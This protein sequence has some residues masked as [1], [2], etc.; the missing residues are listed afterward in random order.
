MKLG[1][2]LLAHG[3]IRPDALNLGIEVDPQSNVVDATGNPDRSLY[4]V[5]PMTRGSY[6]EIV[7][8]PDIRRQC[9]DLARRLANAGWVAEGL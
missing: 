8:V 6:W 5:G 3:R 9:A 7:A 1:E 4:C 2:H